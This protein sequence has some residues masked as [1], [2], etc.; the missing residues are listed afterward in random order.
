MRQLRGIL[1]PYLLSLPSWVYLLIFFL[2]PL[3]SML[4]MALAVGNPLT[5]YTMSDNFSIFG[6]ALSSFGD[7]FIRSFWYGTAST[8]IT[9]AM[10][11]PVAYWIAF[12]GGRHKSTFLF[13]I[14][15][16]FFVSFVIRV[17][18]WEFILSDNSFVL[19]PL[20]EMGILPE[21]FR[22][23]STQWAVIGGL[24][25]NSFAYYVLPLYVVLE[26]IDRRL[27]RAANDLY[28]SP[29]TAFLKIILPLSAPG[30]FAGFL[31]VFVTNVGD[32]VNAALLGGPG[33]YMIGN[34]IQDAFFLNQNYP[35]AAAL[36]SML[37]L[38][39]MLAIL[40]YSKTFGTDTIQ[41]YAA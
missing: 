33:T 15:L 38:M 4:G 23:L 16:P 10:A 12:Y 13:L 1:A 37:M 39:L 22:I 30:V 29:V 35:M 31:L 34:I 26:K 11:Y 24:V 3:G 20:K 8:I 21:K 27:V 19:G 32:F 18:A 25:Y 41:E 14:M 2:I 28:A 17:L 36:S 5:G 6:Q 7:S 40:L 9:L